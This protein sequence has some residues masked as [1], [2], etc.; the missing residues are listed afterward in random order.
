MVVNHYD[1]VN[2]VSFIIQDCCQCN[3]FRHMVV[4]CAILTSLLQDTKWI[5]QLRCILCFS[6]SIIDLAMSANGELCCTVSDDKTA[7]VF[8]VVNFGT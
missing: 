4:F 3:V 7:K 8:D 2:C 1:F 6:G 5:L